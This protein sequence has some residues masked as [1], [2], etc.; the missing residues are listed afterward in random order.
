MAAVTGASDAR[1][2]SAAGGG[3]RMTVISSAAQGR[4]V[5]M[6]SGLQAGDG[7]SMRLWVIHAGTFRSVGLVDGDQPLLAEDVPAGAALGMTDEPEGGSKQPTSAPV[8]SVDLT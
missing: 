3:G 4:A 7:R 1:T 6:P 8:L 2:L 5:V